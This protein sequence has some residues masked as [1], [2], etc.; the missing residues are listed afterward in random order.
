MKI[1][2]CSYPNHICF[3]YYKIPPKPAPKPKV[4]KQSKNTTL[5]LEHQQSSGNTITSEESLSTEEGYEMPI[6]PPKGDY[7]G[8]DDV[9]EEMGPQ[10]LDSQDQRNHTEMRR[11]THTP[12]N[13]QVYPKAKKV[14]PPAVKTIFHCSR[15]V[16]RTRQES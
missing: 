13:P 10:Y 3:Y 16:A 11:T 1:T 15:F 7:A 2:Y 14:S 9:Y 12:A 6:D 4:E 5:K 8:I